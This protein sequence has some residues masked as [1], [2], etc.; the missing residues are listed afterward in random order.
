MMKMTP[1]Y[2]GTVPP[3]R[4]GVYPLSNPIPS[5]ARYENGLWY[6]SEDSPEWAATTRRVSAYQGPER[7]V[8]WA[9]WRGFTE[10]QEG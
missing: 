7:Y 2:P 1:W 8:G 3:A 6:E 4:D 9:A 10:K 5:F